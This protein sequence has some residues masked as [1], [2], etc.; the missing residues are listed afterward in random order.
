MKC[1]LVVNGFLNS[2][3]FEEIYGFLCRSGKKLGID[4]EVKTG[5]DIFCGVNEGFSA[6][7]LPDFVLFWDKDVYTAKRLEE[8]G[9]RLFNSA[10]SVEL[11]DNKCLTAMAL[12][13]KVKTP[14]T[15]IA[16]KTFEGVGFSDLTFLDKAAEKLGYPMVVKEAYGS[17]GKQVYL[18]RNRAEAE[19]LVKSFG[20]K[21]FLMQKFVESSC[22]RDVRINVVGEKVVSAMYR[23]NENDFRSNVTNGGKAENYLPT[24]EQ[25]A[26]AIAAAKALGLDFCGVDV[27]FGEGGEPVIAEVNSNPHFKSTFD[28][29]GIDMSEQILS[30]IK[31]Q[32]K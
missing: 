9:L 5:A 1:W 12:R 18:V 6:F 32:L 31:E 10:A 8:A 28:C 22:G 23:H 17:F 27:L 7:S 3:K 26:A 25:K 20:A 14:E 15:F 29:T 24:E 4:V 13:G 30:Y 2:K 11:C 16:P 21:D 19:T